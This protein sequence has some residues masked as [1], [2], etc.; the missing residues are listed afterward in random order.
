MPARSVAP[1]RHTRWAGLLAAAFG[2]GLFV[3]IVNHTRPEPIV[4]GLRSVGWGFLAVILLSGARVL[5]RATAWR[6][7]T[8]GDELRVRDTFPAFLTGEALGNLTPLGLFVSEPTKAVFVRHRVPL[9]TA[10]S[11]LAIENIL[12]TLSVAVVIA[13]GTVALLFS[14]TV[15][16]TVRIASFVALGGMLLL[17]AIAAWVLGRQVR[18]V[19]GLLDLLHRYHL[20]PAALAHRL[21]KLRALEARVYNFRQ[22]QPGRLLPVLALETAYHAAGVA[23]VWVIVA[24]LVGPPSLLAAFVLET[25]NRATNV[26]FKFVPMRLGVD[27]AGTEWLTSALGYASATGV[28]LAIVRKMRVAFWTAIGVLILTLRGLRRDEVVAMAL[29]TAAADQQPAAR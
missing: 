3:Y 4:A 2:A 25:A 14:F 9:M 15:S 18:F 29:D 6:L 13:A 19:S 7:C 16:P 27:E 28:T 21:E 23:E 5:A 8:E 12:Y 17:L 24:C 1:R 11:G 22:R 26:I 20:A 10:V